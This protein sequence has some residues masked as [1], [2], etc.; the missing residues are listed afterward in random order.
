MPEEK[1]R[2]P[3]TRSFV[4]GITLRYRKFFAQWKENLSFCWKFG[5][6]DAF[7][8]CPESCIYNSDCGKLSL[9]A[10][11]QSDKKTVARSF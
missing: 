5:A 1:K 11:N 4:R 3:F 7:I 8:R 9:S 6:A 10:R 2:S